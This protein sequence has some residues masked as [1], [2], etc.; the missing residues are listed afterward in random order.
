MRHRL[1]ARIA[2]L[3]ALAVSLAGAAWLASRAYRPADLPSVG[4]PPTK[5]EFDGCK[6]TQSDAPLATSPVRS[7]ASEPEASPLFGALGLGP[8]IT[9]FGEGPL[10]ENA[11]GA[12]RYRLVWLRSFHEPVIVTFE[13]RGGEYTAVGKVANGKGG[14]EP[15]IVYQR[16]HVSLTREQ[17]EEVRGWLSQVHFWSRAPEV[18]RTIMDG[19]SWIM[20]GVKDGRYHWIDRQSCGDVELQRIA[21]LMIKATGITIKGPIY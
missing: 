11:A 7:C 9:Q 20:E 17:F 21:M 16:R 19:A 15:G 12:E 6:E 2:L 18:P 8:W 14:Y 10:C 13:S 4:P 3:A 5:P 1:A